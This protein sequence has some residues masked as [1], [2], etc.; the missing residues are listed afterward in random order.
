MPEWSERSE[1]SGGANDEVS[2]GV[3]RTAT[4][5]AVDGALYDGFLSDQDRRLCELVRRMDA[6]GLA[7]CEPEFADPRLGPLLLLYKARNYPTAL[8]AAEAA[9]YEAFCKEKRRRHHS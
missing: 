2:R 8:T 5:A 6:D 1:A 4:L 3:T 9:N 7:D